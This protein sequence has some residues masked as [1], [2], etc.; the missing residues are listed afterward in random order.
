MA[1]PSRS[2]LAAILLVC[3]IGIF[4]VAT[5]REGHVWGDD[6]A[7]YLS[8]TRN[9]VEGKAYGDIGYVRGASSINPLM[10]PPVFPLLLAPVYHFFGANLTPMKIE[11]TVFFCVALFFLYLLLREHGESISIA[12]ITVAAVGLCPY[13]W[14][15]KDSLYSDYPFLAFGFAA[16][17]L[18]GKAPLIRDSIRREIPLGMLVGLLIG[19]AFGART[20]GFI[21]APVIILF[22]CW[23]ARR[24]TSFGVAAGAVS[25]M[26]ALGPSL[27]FHVKSDYLTPYKQ[28]LSLHSLA[29]SPI[30]YLKCFSVVWENGYSVAFQWVLYGLVTVLSLKGFWTRVRSGLSILEV[31]CIAYFLFICLF[32]WGGRR[33]LMPLL[34]FYFFY[35]LF[36]LR[37]F[38]IDRPFALRVSLCGVMALLVSLTFLG[39]Y[40]RHNWEEIGDKWK[41]C[42]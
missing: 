38:T 40:S 39:R 27:A 36:G 9:L 4:Y 7:A 14:D 33:Y 37:S 26:V 29:A 13:F 32:P 12:L 22:D 3:S 15:F 19:L 6:H 17:W 10:Y 2:T 1:T 5:L 41:E 28:T 23:K 31:F 24:I 34:P 8:H 20:V 42:G 16:L 35:I 21:L 25:L 18:A 30:Y 11:C